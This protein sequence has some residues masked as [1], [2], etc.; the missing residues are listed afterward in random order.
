MR[1]SRE[2]DDKQRYIRITA[3]IWMI[4]GVITVILGVMNS[5]SY[6]YWKWIIEVK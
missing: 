2:K 4:A 1:Q 5:I 6:S 3:N